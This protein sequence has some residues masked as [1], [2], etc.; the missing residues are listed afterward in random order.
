MV[1]RF[2]IRA[3]LY[4][5]LLVAALAIGWFS[6]AVEDECKAHTNPNICGKNPFDQR[7]SIV[8]PPGPRRSEVP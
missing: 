7:A 8:E 3:P 5:A 6:V 2:L 1:K 4:I